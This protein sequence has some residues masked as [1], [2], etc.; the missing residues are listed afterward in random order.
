MYCGLVPER[1]VCGCGAEVQH[2]SWLDFAGG[3]DGTY[4]YIHYSVV[5]WLESVGGGGILGLQWG[6]APRGSL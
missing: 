6:S 1:W 2:V 4:R 3:W 5:G